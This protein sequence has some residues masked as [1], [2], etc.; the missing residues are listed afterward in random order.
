METMNLPLQSTENFKLNGGNMTKQE[1]A[2]AIEA[3]KENRKQIQQQ[4]SASACKQNGATP[5][6]RGHFTKA[7][8]DTRNHSSKDSDWTE[9]N[10][11]F[12]QR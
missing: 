12:D 2:Q 11:R 10:K 8:A 3:F 6:H 7:A 5:R 9:Y 4:C 1:R